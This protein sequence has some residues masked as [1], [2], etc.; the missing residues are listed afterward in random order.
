MENQTQTEN[1]IDLKIKLPVPLQSW[2][3]FLFAATFFLD[4]VNTA[5]YA[6]EDTEDEE[7]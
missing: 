3:I 7:E 6:L 4:A 2:F 1:F 5:D